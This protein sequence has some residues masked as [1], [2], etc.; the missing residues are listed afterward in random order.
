MFASLFR[1]VLRWPMY[2]PRRFWTIVVAL[3]VCVL[4]LGR[5]GG[6]PQTAA[7]PASPAPGTLSSSALAVATPSPAQTVT[8]AREAEPP[9]DGAPQAE[10]EDPVDVA[11]VVVTAWATA[12]GDRRRWRKDLAPY[13]TTDLYRQLADVDLSTIPATELTGSAQLVERGDDFAHLRVPTDAGP[14]LVT[15]TLTDDR[16]L[17]SSLLLETIGG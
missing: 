5:C 7:A 6:A 1:A 15:L 13:V 11:E 8:P 4:L 3:G 10:V 17:A 9:I 14:V 12:S 16:W 2:S